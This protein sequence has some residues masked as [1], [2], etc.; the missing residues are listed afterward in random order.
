MRRLL[1]E[2]GWPP[3][4]I[5]LLLRAN[6][7]EE[8]KAREAWQTWRRTRV[9]E[10]A[11]WREMRLLA[12]LARRVRVLEP[13][14]ELLPR[15]DGMAKSHWTQTQLILKEIVPALDALDRAGIPCLL[16]KGGADYAEGLAPAIRRIM[17][18]VD[19]LVPREDVV[20]ATDVLHGAGWVSS[21]GESLP[22]LRSLAPVRA[23]TNYRRGRFGDIDLHRVAFHF[24]RRDAEL[25]AG[26]W[27]RARPVL[28]AGKNVLVPSGEDSVLISL[29][30]GVGG[31]SSDWAMDVGHRISVS[32]LDWDRMVDAATGRGLVPTA[33]AGLT[34]L[35]SLDL[36]VPDSAIARL[37]ALN[38]PLGEWL[39]YWSN[40]RG[41]GLRRG[42][43]KKVTNRIA[44]LA[45][46]RQ[47]YDYRVKGDRVVPVRRPDIRP[48]LPGQAVDVAD[49]ARAWGTSHSLRIEPAGAECVIALRV[50]SPAVSRRVFFDVCAGD[51]AIARLRAR[52]GGRRRGERALRFSFPLPNQSGRPVDLTIESRPVSYVG[53]RAESG[54]RDAFAAVPFLLI[55]AWAS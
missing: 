53:T 42:L 19:I 23:S 35:R 11:E 52:L 28:F 54:T 38:V 24:S 44:D 10:D 36:P 49:G 9:L 30:H 43:A 47:R 34:Y 2:H 1:I 40:I 4:H 48:R 32:G 18:D 33:L 13:G 31:N 27:R 25:D 14:C 15:L 51:L 50:R 55:G 45:L 7:A 41:S 21:S 20:R 37:R 6:L 3:A 22:Y 16:F 46:P 29:A 12:P 8:S 17:G 5:D 39:K 26:L